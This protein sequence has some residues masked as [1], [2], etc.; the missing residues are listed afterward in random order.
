[1]IR[2]QTSD[3]ARVNATTLARWQF[4]STTLYHYLIVPLTIGLTMLV[5]IMQTN[6]Y[7]KRDSPR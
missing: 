7:L 3:G 1:M 4:A 6:A 5:A 2:P